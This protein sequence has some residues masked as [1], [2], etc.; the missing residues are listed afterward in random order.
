MC[1][2]SMNCKVNIAHSK[3]ECYKQALFFSASLFFVLFN[4]HIVCKIRK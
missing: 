2:Q 4:T 1:K 3:Q